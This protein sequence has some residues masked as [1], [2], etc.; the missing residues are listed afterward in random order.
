[1]PRSESEAMIRLAS[2]QINP[3]VGDI[4]GNIKLIIDA[5]KTAEAK[6]AQIVL[7]PEMV[8]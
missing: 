1:M 4:K 8:V 6:G 5:V 7:F 2:A 3:V